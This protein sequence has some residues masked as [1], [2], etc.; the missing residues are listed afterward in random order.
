MDDES[1]RLVASRIRPV[2]TVLRDIGRAMA[3]H[4]AS[5]PADRATLE[6][7]AE[8]FSR[9][10]GKSPVVL[11]IELRR[12]TPAVKVRASLIGTGVR[13]AEQLVEEVEQLCGKG[14]VS[15]G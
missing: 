8:I 14:V 12:N 13:R 15:W 4:L 2:D 6:A 10:Q 7:L 9:H 11:E 3:I 1:S 5:P